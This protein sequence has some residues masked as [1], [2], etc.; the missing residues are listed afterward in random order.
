MS[1]EVVEQIA[2]KLQELSGIMLYLE[3]TGEPFIHPQIMDIIR[4]LKRAGFDLTIFTNG[5]LLNAG[6]VAELIEARVSVVRF[7]LW[8]GA[9]STF[10]R[11]YPGSD[12]KHFHRITESLQHFQRLRR[13]TGA[14]RPKVNIF[15]VVNKLNKDEIP[16]VVELA[17]QYRCDG[18]SFGRFISFGKETDTISFN[19]QERVGLMEDLK[20]YKAVLN[21]KSLAHTLA[22]DIKQLAAGPETWFHSP[23]LV[24]WFHLQILVN[25]DVVPCCRSSYRLGNIAEQSLTEIWD[26]PA[27]NEFRRRAAAPDG[28]E[29][30]EKQGTNCT[31]C[32]HIMQMKKLYPWMRVINKIKKIEKIGGHFPDYF[33]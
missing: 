10:E 16:T 31:D 24:C 11:D 25:G 5:T 4:R 22:R 13:Q 23:C 18:I 30:L 3:G 27:I 1:L 29:W 2:S 6:L 15:F 19:R 20:Q 21:K 12:K 33:R 28:H 7:S 17:D 26:G 8:A 9:E 32:P 14:A